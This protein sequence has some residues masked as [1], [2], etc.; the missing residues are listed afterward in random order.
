MGGLCCS[1]YN[2]RKEFTL[3]VDEIKVL[4]ISDMSNCQILLN[5]GIFKEYLIKCFPK[6]Y[7]FTQCPTLS[8][9]LDP[10]PTKSYFFWN[11]CPTFKKMEVAALNYQVARSKSFL[12]NPQRYL[13]S[14]F[15]LLMI[16]WNQISLYIWQNL[17]K[18]LWSLY[19]WS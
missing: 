17:V 3:V 11:F 6:S 4:G 1:F 14:L 7:I 9:F 18:F 16:I 5:L 8:Y 2:M 19:I 12:G 10:C 15:L 13:L